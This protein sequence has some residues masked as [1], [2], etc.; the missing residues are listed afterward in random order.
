MLQA[1]LLLLQALLLLLQ[2]L[3]QALV[4]A[5]LQ[6]VLPPRVS[7][8]GPRSNCLPARH[9]C[10]GGRG[11]M[12]RRNRGRASAACN[13]ACNKACGVS[14][15]L[16]VLLLLLLLLLHTTCHTCMRNTSPPCI[17]AASCMQH[18]SSIPAGCGGLLGVLPDVLPARLR[19]RKMSRREVPVTP[20]TAPPSPPQGRLRKMR[21]REL[22]AASAS[23]SVARRPLR[24]Y[25][26]FS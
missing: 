12:S 24:I 25:M 14:L 13:K 4:Q 5:L 18:T 26:R 23:L 19:L 8:L 21:R 11:R 3:V 20:T 16:G 7:F 15:L 17:Y 10:E 1:L 6:A 22:P 2:A 9:G